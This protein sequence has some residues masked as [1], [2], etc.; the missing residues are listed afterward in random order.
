MFVGV[1][2]SV[3]TL[4]AAVR[5]IDDGAGLGL[6]IVASRNDFLGEQS[7]SPGLFAVVV[8]HG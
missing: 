1:V 3:P 8:L 5:V 6:G 4:L 2:I 7:G